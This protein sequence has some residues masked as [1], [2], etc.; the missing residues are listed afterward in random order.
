MFLFVKSAK[1]AAL[2]ES[3]VK[4]FGRIRRVAFLRSMAFLG[5]GKG[6]VCEELKISGSD[7][8]KLHRFMGAGLK[9]FCKGW[10]KG[11]MHIWCKDSYARTGTPSSQHQTGYRG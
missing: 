11:L 8:K 5:S 2:G 1:L 10:A 9:I 7:E 6:W 4:L 3:P